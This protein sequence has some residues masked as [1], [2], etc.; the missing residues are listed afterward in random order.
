MCSSETT[1]HDTTARLY[2][3]ARCRAQTIICRH[4]DRGH[5][6]CAAC[7]PLAAQEARKRASQRYQASEQ[8]QRH[9]AARQ[10]RYRE[11]QQKKV[12]HKGCAES[13]NPL[14]ALFPQI[15]PITPPAPT[16]QVRLFEHVCHF[17]EALCSAFL[18]LDFLLRPG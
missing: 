3:C 18:R 12:T 6:Y 14:K 11:R 9:H 7:A 2:V 4:C 16:P 1:T 15:R 8:G 10:Q 5:R 13:V 17:C